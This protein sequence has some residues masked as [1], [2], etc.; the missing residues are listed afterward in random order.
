MTAEPTEAAVN[1][2]RSSVLGRA[3]ALLMAFALEDEWIGPSELGRRADLP[4]PTA[5]RLALQLSQH[6]LL[7]YHDGMFRLGVRL[8]E[9]GHRVV[10]E[11]V[12]RERAI[13]IMTHV[14]ETTG[15]TV[16]LAELSGRDVLYLA[17]LHGPLSPQPQPQP[18]PQPRV[19]D[20]APAHATAL[21]KVLLA[22]APAPMQHAALTAPLPRLT[23]R[24]IVQPGRLR[25]VLDTVTSQGYAIDQGECHSGQSCAAAPVLANDSTAVA[26]LSV[27]GPSSR[28]SILRAKAAVKAAAAALT[29]DLSPQCPSSSL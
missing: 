18:Q 4:K 15:Y 5:H 2:A 22:Y 26:A 28:F 16:H 1:T 12:I 11:S 19:G 17:I 29:R 3:S 7:E 21:G 23:S 9:L 27:A 6:G 13:P 14:R 10:R 20:R 25:A 24:T 8:F